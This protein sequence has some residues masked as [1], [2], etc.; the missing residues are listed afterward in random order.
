M[1]LTPPQA[2]TPRH[3]CQQPQNLSLE[4][5]GSFLTPPLTI[6]DIHPPHSSVI[7]TPFFPLFTPGATLL[8]AGSPEHWSLERGFHSQLTLGNTTCHVRFSKGR[9][10][11]YHGKG[12][13]KSCKEICLILRNTAFSKH[14][15]Q[16][17]PFFPILNLFPPRDTDWEPLSGSLTIA[18]PLNS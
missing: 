15:Q 2:Q 1:P 12:S 13:D 3:H 11:H 16:Q 7:P 8:K 5:V 9:N 6:L 18:S 14:T 10:D 4:G 17:N